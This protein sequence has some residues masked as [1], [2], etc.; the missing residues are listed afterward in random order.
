MYTIGS[1]LHIYN[2]NGERLPRT[3]VAKLI[4]TINA[5]F[6]RP[7]HVYL[8]SNLAQTELKVGIAEIIEKRRKEHEYDRG[9]A[10]QVL[11]ATAA[12]DRAGAGQIERSIQ[13]FL[14]A[15]GRKLTYKT[16]WFNLAS[17]DVWLIQQMLNEMPLKAASPIFDVLTTE[18][19]AYLAQYE[20]HPAYTLEEIQIGFGRNV[21][22]H[23]QR[24]IQSRI[25]R[26]TQ[27]RIVLPIAG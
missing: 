12:I 27:G 2:R 16:E 3:E 15:I 13:R 19:P 18:Y 24:E 22:Y 21:E 17:H 4:D 7:V 9:F 5:N 25:I 20:M 23:F 1:D 10:V 26:D 8:M 11:H 14:F 6:S